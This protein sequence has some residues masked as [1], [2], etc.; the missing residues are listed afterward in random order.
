MDN[1]RTTLLQK[2]SQI[3]AGKDEPSAGP[4][5]REYPTPDLTVPSSQSLASLGI[6]PGKIAAGSLQLIG[7]TGI[8]TALGE[9]WEQRSEQIFRLI[10]G[11]F[12]RRLDVTQDAPHG[13]RERIV[14]TQLPVLLN[15]PSGPAS[16]LCMEASLE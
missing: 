3:L 5:R 10:E 14:S 1:N 7:L 2:L 16:R 12:R 13:R 8:R 9:R 6:T 4:R 11:I 15:C